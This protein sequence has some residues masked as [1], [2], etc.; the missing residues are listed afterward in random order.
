MLEKPS[1]QGRAPARGS[2]GSGGPLIS[3]EAVNGSIGI[4]DRSFGD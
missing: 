2:I 4:E 3:A 1:V